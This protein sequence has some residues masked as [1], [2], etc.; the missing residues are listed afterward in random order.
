MHGRTVK[1]TSLQQAGVGVDGCDGAHALGHNGIANGV[2]GVCLAQNVPENGVHV[3]ACCLVPRPQVSQDL[4]KF[5]LQSTD[6]QVSQV[7]GKDSLPIRLRCP[8]EENIGQ[9]PAAI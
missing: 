8:Y 5:Y 6:A 3:V 7:S 1:L 2:A 9:R 4:Q